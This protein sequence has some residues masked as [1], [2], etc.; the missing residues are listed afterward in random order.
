MADVSLPLGS[1][2]IPG[3]SY[4]FLTAT[5]HSAWTAAVLYL[6]HLLIKK[7]TCTAFNISARTSQKTSF[8]C[9]CYGPMPCNGRCTK[10]GWYAFGFL[11]KIT[12]YGIEKNVFTLHIPP[13]AP[14]TYDFVVLTS[15]THPRKILL[16]VLQIGKYEIEKT[17]DLPHPY[18]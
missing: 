3:L 1:R 12:R 8:L 13:W 5:A 6:T 7:P 10:G 17:K 18:V 15:L 2:N 14:H 4:Q 16:L 11:K 9:C